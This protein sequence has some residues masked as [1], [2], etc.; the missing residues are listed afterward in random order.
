M[1]PYF[2]KMILTNQLIRQIV[3]HIDAINYKLLTGKNRTDID[4]TYNLC[5]I[6]T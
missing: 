3:N 6:I 2:N 1:L 5:P 4:I